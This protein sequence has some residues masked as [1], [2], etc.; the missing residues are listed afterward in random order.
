MRADRV[1]VSRDE[2]GKRWVIRIEVGAEVI[3]RHSN[4]SKGATTGDLQKVA[5]GIAAE[6]GYQVEPSDVVVLN[7]EEL[8][9]SA[10]Q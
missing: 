3:R 8:T 7:K 6:E 2:A 5:A 1:E 10:G 9:R 4:E